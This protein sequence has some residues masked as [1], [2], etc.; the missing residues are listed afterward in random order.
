MVAF[1][2]VLLV[3]H[4]STL[5]KWLGYAS[6]REQTFSAV[7]WQSTGA[8]AKLKRSVAANKGTASSRVELGDERAASRTGVVEGSSGRAGRTERSGGVLPGSVWTHALEQQ[9]SRADK[10]HL[11]LASSIVSLLRC[12]RT[13]P[14]SGKFE[15][16]ETLCWC[17][18]FESCGAS[19]RV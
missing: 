1:A 7:L 16:D 9:R 10:T 14:A 5:T 18:G 3:Q 8:F 11:S 4:C 6:S 15:S 2:C 19:R 13:K 17:R 12:N